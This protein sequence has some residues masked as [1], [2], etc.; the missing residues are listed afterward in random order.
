MREVQDELATP[1]V[2][3]KVAILAAMNISDELFAEKRDRDKIKNEVERKVSSL[4][5]I[6]EESI[7]QGAFS[8]STGLTGAPGMYA[9]TDEIVALAEVMAGYDNAFYV[10]H[11]RVWGGNH[12]GAIQEAMEIGFRAQVPVQFSHM[13]I[14]DPRAYGDGEQMLDVIERARSDG[15]DATYD[16]Y[17]YTAAGSGLAQSLPSWIQVGGDQEMLRI[18]YYLVG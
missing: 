10:T 7:E 2:P 12:I 11:A 17:P 8:M 14:I 3:A 4:I 15:L 16:V 6:V 13:A 5:E 18:F 9:D 1:Q